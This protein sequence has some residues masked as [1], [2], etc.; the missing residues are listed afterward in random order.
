MR[1]I[2]GFE[3]PDKVKLRFTER[4]N[5]AD[6]GRVFQY[7]TNL[8]QWSVVVPSAM[9]Q[10]EDRGSVVIR[11]VTLPAPHTQGFYTSTYPPP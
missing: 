6:L 9:V 10:L 2:S 4:K 8:I 11:E 5:A 3:G 1:R 7:S